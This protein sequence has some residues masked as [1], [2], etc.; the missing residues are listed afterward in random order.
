MANYK[1]QEYYVS[2]LKH[3]VKVN[4]DGDRLYKYKQF[5]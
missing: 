4:K 2:C 5:M 1:E 3:I